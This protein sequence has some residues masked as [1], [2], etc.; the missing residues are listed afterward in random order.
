ML[1]FRRPPMRP[2]FGLAN[3]TANL[4]EITIDA[5]AILESE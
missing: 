5:E 3:R 4:V 2:G 1:P